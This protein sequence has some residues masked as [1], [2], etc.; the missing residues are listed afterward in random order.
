MYVLPSILKQ[1]RSSKNVSQREVSSSIGVTER[2]Y[3]NYESGNRKPNYDNLIAIADYYNVSID[4]LTGRTDET[5]F[6]HIQNI[7]N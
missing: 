3:Q 7:D 4:Y 5:S 1:L 2:N 6:I